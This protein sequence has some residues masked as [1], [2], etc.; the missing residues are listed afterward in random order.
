MEFSFSLEGS[1]FQ[2]FSLAYFPENV[3]TFGPQGP[4]PAS[5]LTAANLEP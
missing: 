5:G 4:R 2:T 3:F 1:K